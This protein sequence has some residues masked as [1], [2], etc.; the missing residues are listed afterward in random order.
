MAN[1]FGCGFARVAVKLSILKANG[2]VEYDHE[3]RW[4]KY[5]E[6]FQ[7]VHKSR[8]EVDKNL[9][10]KR[11]KALEHHFKRW[12]TTTKKIYIE[13]FS[14]TNWEKLTEHEKKQHSLANCKACDVHHFSYQ[15]LFPLWGNKIKT[16]THEGIYKQINSRILK[17]SSAG[18]V[19][20]TKKALKSATKEVYDKINTT[21]EK[22]FGVSF[23]IAQTSVPELNVQ[24]KKSRA[25]LKKERRNQSRAC[26]KHI[27]QQW[28]ENACDTM[29]ATR[30]TYNQRHEQR[31]FL[32]FETPEEAETRAKKR[33]LLEEQGQRKWKRHSPNPK[34]LEFD[35]N[36]LL[37]E[38]N[39]MKDGE[40]VSK[41]PKIS[42]NSNNSN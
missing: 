22:T 36:E 16:V 7:G 27:E 8:F 25:E 38:V 11:S 41:Q 24:V 28:T 31:M 30:Q 14:Q 18:N 34:D 21:F 10:T 19:K 20:V 33:K 13:H 26:K 35:E 17:E 37:Q 1:F 42:F 2:K 4:K 5:S 12:K 32:C 40:K 29:L 3:Q 23:A 9:Y 15:S 6:I 39:A